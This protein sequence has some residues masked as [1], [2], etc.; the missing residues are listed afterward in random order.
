MTLSSIIKAQ[1]A[2]IFAILAVTLPSLVYMAKFKNHTPFGHQARQELIKSSTLVR[3]VN[4]NQPG[5][6]RYAY[7]SD[8]RPLPINVYFTSTAKPHPQLTQWLSDM[9]TSTLN[10]PIAI[11]LTTS[12]LETNSA[13]LADADLNQLRLQLQTSRLSK[14]HLNII[15]VP[16]YF[17]EPSFAGLTLHRDTIF[18]FSNAVNLLSQDP[19]EAANL[20]H[21][22]LLHEWGHLLGLEHTETA[23][24]IMSAKVDL[25]TNDQAWKNHLRTNYC[26]HELFEL[27][28]L[29]DQSKSQ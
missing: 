18:I 22:T 10:R 5:D 26:D 23:E 12:P 13:G 14:P 8:Y 16:Y 6:F 9:I 29:R 20:E 11:N 7:F 17:H 19:Q 3:L 2:F 4:F 1:I 15:Y 27:Q 24:C 25:Y 28:L 21:S